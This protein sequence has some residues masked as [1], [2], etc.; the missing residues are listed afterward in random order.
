VDGQVEVTKNMSLTILVHKKI[1]SVG[2]VK[3]FLDPKISI[4]YPNGPITQMS[5][6]EFRVSG[7]AWV[8]YHFEEYMTIRISEEKVRRVFAPNEE[9]AFLKDCYPIRIRMDDSGDLTLIPQ[10]FTKYTLA[11]LESLSKDKRRTI[12]K[13]SP[14][15]VFWKAFDEVLTIAKTAEN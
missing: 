7:Y 2:I 12:S 10:I 11:N 1:A 5:Q 4:S 15:D 9:K 3:W 6:E 8:R 13:D 14:P